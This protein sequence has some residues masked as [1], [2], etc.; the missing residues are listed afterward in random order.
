MD[1]VTPAPEPAGRGSLTVT[2]LAV[3]APGLP[4]TT[5]KPMR[6]PALTVRASGV[7]VIV[8]EAQS[9]VSDAGLE[10]LPALLVVTLGVLLY[11]AQFCAVVGAVM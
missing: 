5:V 9:T 7:L 8:M 11:A 10:P 1:Q 2:P 3:P 4:T 6:S